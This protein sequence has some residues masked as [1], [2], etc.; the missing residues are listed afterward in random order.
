[1]NKS[2][3]KNRSVRNTKKK[4]RNALLTLMQEKP[5]GEI[6]VKE[7][8]E[9]ADVNRGTFYFHYSDIFS[10]LHQI[11]DVFFEQFVEVIDRFDTADEPL[12]YLTALFT[13]LGEN[14]DMVGIMLGVNSD[15]V[16]MEQIRRFLWDKFD[17]FWRT[18]APE[19][20][21][22]GARLYNAFLI[23][24]FVGIVKKWISDGL[25][26]TPEEIS[27]FVYTIINNTMRL[28]VS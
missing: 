10:L 5:V 12:V 15:M 9:L 8:T 20:S 26:E 25:Q 22:G 11:E 27:Q 7:L 17:F 21:S 2:G 24:G 19:A 1:M 16:F 18:I 28:C 3:D 6:T 14:S 23:D 4:L 13:F